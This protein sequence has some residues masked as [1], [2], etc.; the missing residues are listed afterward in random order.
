MERQV[1]DVIILGGG[2]SGMMCACSINGKSVAVVDAGTRPAKKLM[3]TG[4]GRC[5]LTNL[6]VSSDAYNQNIDKYLKKFNQRQTLQFFKRLGLE[7][8]ADEQGRVYPLSNSA[9]SVVDVLNFGAKEVKF[10]SERQALDVKKDASGFV[11]TL[12]NI[13]LV[14]EKLVLATG[15]N[16]EKVLQ[17]LGVNYKKFVPSL[18][19]LESKGTRDLNG[20]RVS[21][22]L[23]TATNSFGE[24]KSEIGEVLFRENGLS[25]IVV[26]N[27]STLFSRKDS[28]KGKVKIDLLP[29][30]SEKALAEMLSE[31]RRLA[32][33]LDKFFVGMFA[34][35]VANEIFKQSKLNTNLNCLKLQEKEISLLAKTIKNLEF[36][37]CGHLDNNQVFSGGVPLEVLDDR[38]MHKK[39]A[40]LYCIGEVCDVDGVCGGF[41]LQWAWTSGHIVGESL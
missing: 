34:G 2:A 32:V 30:V 41:N 25:G 1:F 21:N 7:T 14:S 16:S 13:Q 22:V 24:I 18:V 9:K 12:G 20:I 19:S 35:G 6:N 26:F 29:D 11:V 3:V 17:E 39:I 38:L 15:G 8:Y 36:D 28:F 23:V 10:F 31:R 4:N 33:S 37:I 27:L 40:N 5:N